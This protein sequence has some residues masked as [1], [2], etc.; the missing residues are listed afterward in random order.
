MYTFETCQLDPARFEL[1]RAGVAVHVEPQ[2]FEVLVYLLTHRDRVVPKT[3]LLDAVWGN[4]FVSDSTLTSRLKEARKAI[5][6]DGQGQRLIATVRGVGYRFVAPV[7]DDEPAPAADQRPR[8]KRAAQEI[9][10]CTSPDG[11]RIA[12]ASTGAG[13]P[14]VK[15]ANWLTHLDLEW[16]SPIWAHWI[17]ALSARH[18]L[19]RYDERGCGMS[20]WEVRDFS[21][22]AWVEDLELVVDSVGLERFPLLGMSQGG[23]VALAYAVR[24]P[25]RVTR[26]VLV[27]AY[28]RGRLARAATP[29]EHEEAALD[30]QVGRVGWRRD[31]PAYRQVFASQF[32][33]DADRQ[34]WDAFNAPPASHD[35]HR[36]RRALPR[37]LRQPR[38]L[39]AGGAGHL[40]D[41]DRARPRRPPRADL[42]GPRAGGTDPGQPGA[43]GRQR[44]PHR[45]GRRAGVARAGRRAG[46]VPR[47]V[48]LR[49]ASRPDP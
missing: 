48:S 13:P 17:D 2:V 28:A 22:D 6:D 9:R 20:D 45:D 35:L 44:Q 49:P 8:G 1:Q 41:A 18:R 31:D 21:L 23:A 16:G 14:M 19:I 38:R 46:R 32:L 30:L 4:R 3:E 26:I 5:G 47:R 40:P 12:Y 25:E 7:T 39:G 36:E 43:P 37:H 10:Y 42:A 34:R 29:E 15:A 33:P 24:H 27:G 11:V